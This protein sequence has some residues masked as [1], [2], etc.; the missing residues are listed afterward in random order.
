MP[1]TRLMP[2]ARS[3]LIEWQAAG[4]KVVH[5]ADTKEL[6]RRAGVPVPCRDPQTGLCV[7]KLCSDRYPH[8]TEYGF[9]KL[10]VPAAESG[11]VASALR[12]RETGGVILVEEMISDGVAEWIVGCRHDP[13]FGPIVVIGAGGV[14][15]EL[16]DEAKARLAPLDAATAEKAIRSQRAAKLL[17]GLRG[18][19]AGDIPAL[20]DAVTRVSIFF[21][22]HADSIEQ[23]EINPVIVRPAGR[24]TV[25]ADALLILRSPN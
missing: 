12:A 4:R 22:E 18:K 9:V 20:I 13:T 2:D 21:A 5:E 25:A 23:I 11:E 19:P 24:G 3:Q 10:N 6:L 14:L 8:K 17:G 16:I 1:D 15:V 7:V